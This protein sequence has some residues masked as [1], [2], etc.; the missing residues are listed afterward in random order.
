MGTMNS[1]KPVVR[2]CP[3]EQRVKYFTELKL[4]TDE[5]FKPIGFRGPMMNSELLPKD[6]LLVIFASLRPVHALGKVAIVCQLWY[7]V[8]TLEDALWIP[9]DGSSLLEPLDS[10]DQSIKRKVYLQHCCHAAVCVP[11]SFEKT[12]LAGYQILKDERLKFVVLGI[13]GVGKSTLTLQFSQELFY[14]MFLACYSDLS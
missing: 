3:F 8:S 1:K 4:A 6:I 9:F 7:N 14:G 2:D 11:S 10:S 13:G 12:I 5:L